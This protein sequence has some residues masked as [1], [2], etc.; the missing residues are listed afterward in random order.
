MHSWFVSP[1]RSEVLTRGAIAIGC[2]V[3]ATALWVVSWQNYTRNWSAA[4]K[5]EESSWQWAR[6]MRCMLT[7]IL[8]CV[9]LAEIYGMPETQNW[10]VVAV[11]L[12]ALGI[13]AMTISKIFS[14]GGGDVDWRDVP[15][16]TLIE[17]LVLVAA[18][19]MHVLYIPI[20]LFG[21]L[22]V[23]AP[24]KSAPD[25]PDTDN[26]GGEGWHALPNPEVRVERKRLICR[27]VRHACTSRVRAAWW[28]MRAGG[29]ANR[30]TPGWTPLRLRREVILCRRYGRRQ[31]EQAAPAITAGSVAEGQ[32]GGRV[33]TRRLGALWH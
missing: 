19:L 24:P 15:K 18:F 22:T 10:W 28:K 6:V 9:I 2:I 5:I 33:R 30:T 4:E 12:Y 21:R 1:I 27:R 29:E 16:F 17:T 7:V 11:S 13:V 20:W 3:V 14:P 25:V 31:S 26:R 8:C 23:A 32:V